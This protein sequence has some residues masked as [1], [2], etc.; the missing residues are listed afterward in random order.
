[1]AWG[2]YQ[3]IHT[4]L[5]RFLRFQFVHHT[6]GYGGLETVHRPFPRW[7]RL[8]AFGGEVQ[9]KAYRHVEVCL[10][11]K[12]LVGLGALHW[13]TWAPAIGGHPLTRKCHTH[14]GVL[15]W[16]PS[17]RLLFL[18]AASQIGSMIPGRRTKTVSPTKALGN[19]LV[20]RVDESQ[21]SFLQLLLL[22]ICVFLYI[23]ANS[24]DYIISDLNFF[25]LC[26]V[27]LVNGWV[28]LTRLCCSHCQCNGAL[29]K[30]DHMPQGLS[31]AVV[32]QGSGRKQCAVPPTLAWRG[33]TEQFVPVWN[34]VIHIRGLK[35]EGGKP[36][37]KATGPGCI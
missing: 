37:E 10:E 8:R 30:V 7:R 33:G 24:L 26:F 31:A 22:V 32:P 1:M 3:R 35:N 27:L 18:T 34:P 6:S 15:F 19:S 5:L 2:N 21:K 36:R 29:T 12:H 25:F 20:L 13:V 11:V 16:E 17:W 4:S 14:I 9:G 23:V 28:G